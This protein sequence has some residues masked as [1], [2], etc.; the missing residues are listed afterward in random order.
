MTDSMIKFQAFQLGAFAGDMLISRGVIQPDF[1]IDNIG[2]RNGIPVLVDYA[3]IIKV[4]LPKELTKDVIRI[5]KESLFSLVDNYEGSFKSNSYVR[6]GFISRTGMLGHMIYES[7][8]DNGYS[9]FMFVEKD[10]RC[11][12]HSLARITKWSDVKSVIGEWME[13]P[14]DLFDAEKT[15]DF[16][17]KKRIFAYD[18]NE[19]YLRNTIHI[20]ALTDKSIMSENRNVMKIYLEMSLSALQFGL[21]Y[22]AYGFANKCKAI[23]D[24]IQVV[25][26]CDIILEKTQAYVE[27]YKDVVDRYINREAFELMW[28]LEDFDISITK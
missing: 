21:P 6:A 3:D 2:T 28:I 27:E 18:I 7:T 25:Q 20:W 23:T 5:I 11:K 13:I 19:Y 12:E 9:S 15:D 4:N 16:N 17:N 10:L 8:R 22:M 26:T 1:Q 14:L 24:N